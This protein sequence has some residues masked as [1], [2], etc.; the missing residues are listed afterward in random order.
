MNHWPSVFTIYRSITFLTFEIWT[1]SK[2][3]TTD[4]KQPPNHCLQ[5]WTQ[6]ET[7]SKINV[8]INVNNWFCYPCSRN[9]WV[10]RQ[11]RKSVVW[12]IRCFFS[13]AALFLS[14]NLHNMTR[15]G[16]IFQISRNAHVILSYT[17]SGD[18]LPTNDR[19]PA[20]NMS[21]I[22]RFHCNPDWL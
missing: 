8:K 17:S 12:I 9:P 19:I 11:A 3:W 16:E 4:K 6:I 10:F 22:Q 14:L 13:Q 2:L 1:A 20:P 15:I 21:A 5:E 18:N 7:T